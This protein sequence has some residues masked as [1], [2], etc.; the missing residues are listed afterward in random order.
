MDDAIAKGFK[1]AKRLTKQHAKTFYF[2][3]KLLGKKKRQAA[4]SVYAI[5]RISDDSVDGP[6]GGLQKLRNIEEKINLAYNSDCY[7]E[8]LLLA[9]KNTVKI[10]NIPQ[11]YFNQLIE[12]MYMDLDK[13]S[14]ADF[15]QLYNYCYKVAGVV[16][17]IM[18]HIFGYQDEKARQ[19]AVDLGIAMQLTNI[20]RD[21]KE[22][23]ERNR[24]YLPQEDMQEY[25]VTEEDLSLAKINKNLINLIKF[26]IQRARIYYQFANKGIRMIED[27]RSRLVVCAM[28]KI[29]GAILN[30]IEKNNYDLFSKRASVNSLTKLGFLVKI[31]IKGE[32]R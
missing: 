13:K 23:F 11:I 20:L 18:L 29:Y 8:P 27:K 4:Y 25:K 9:F 31:I 2:A 28:S 5:C 6:G 15:D 16:G 21:V 3:S 17:L 19:P 1:E 10:Y 14:Y 7:Q 22:D 24:I 30:Q 12:G 32:Y 26:Q